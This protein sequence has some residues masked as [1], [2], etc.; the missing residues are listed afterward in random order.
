M[1]FR[2]NSKLL[3]TGSYHFEVPHPK[4]VSK[5]KECPSLR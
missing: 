1:L 3:V 5:M 4:E 2:S